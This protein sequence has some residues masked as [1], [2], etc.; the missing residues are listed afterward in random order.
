MSE[1]PE[2]DNSEVHGDKHIIASLMMA[3]EIA[4]NWTDIVWNLE[5]VSKLAQLVLN[6]LMENALNGDKN[7]GAE[8]G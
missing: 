3:Q 6:R 1:D 8:I 5:V 4:K 2:M 7:I